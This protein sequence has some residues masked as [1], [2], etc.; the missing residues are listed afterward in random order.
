LVLGR[1]VVSRSREAQHVTDG[2]EHY[3]LVLD[4]IVRQRILVRWNNCIGAP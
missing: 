1:V 3:P 4:A 2:G